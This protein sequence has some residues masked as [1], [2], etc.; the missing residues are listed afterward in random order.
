MREDRIIQSEEEVFELARE[1]FGLDL[2]KY[3]KTSEGDDG[4]YKGRQTA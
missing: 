4:D 2:T 1:Y 3:T